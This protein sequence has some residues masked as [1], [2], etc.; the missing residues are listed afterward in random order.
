[1]GS[2]AQ[3]SQGN[4]AVGYSFGNEDKKPGISYTGKLASEPS[5]TF[6]SDAELIA[7]TGV[8]KAFG[9]RWGDY[10]A[11][12]I[13]P[14]DDCSFWLTNQYYS[15]ESQEES[16]FGWLTRIGRFKFAEC[17]PAQLGS[18]G[19]LVQN[20]STQAAIPNARVRVVPNPNANSAPYTRFSGS[21][22]Q[23]ETLQIPAG[24][25]FVE[26]SADGFR[27]SNIQIGLPPSGPGPTFNLIAF[28]TPVAVVVNAGAEISAESCAVNA[29]IEP[30]ETVSMNIALRNTGSVNAI[31]LTATLLS[32]GGVLNPSG[33]QNYGALTPNGM[34][35]SRPFTFTANPNLSCG[36]VLTLNF[37]LNDGAEDL[38]IVSINRQTGTPRTAFAEHF[39]NFPLPNLPTG[40]TSSATGGQLPWTTRETRFQSPPNAVFSPDP[41]EVGLNE[42]VSPPFLVTS[43][44]AQINF[45][46]WYEL[47]T[48][49]MTVR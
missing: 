12:N 27:T 14:K 22:G 33:A 26:V 24:N 49:F 44:N 7:G 16:D 42:L 4:I 32:T 8:Q 35:A 23:T 20:S 30:G 19:F 18:L 17:I 48:D 47:E 41:R 15:L 46:N 36:S 28:L 3:D 25:Y 37:Q 6:R 2:A 5:G 11:M 10:S 9:F 21:N 39:D 43:S 13:D 29:S 1:M 45:R 34:A 40:W 31:N 38:G